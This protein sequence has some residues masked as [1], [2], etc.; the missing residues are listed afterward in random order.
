MYGRYRLQD[1]YTNDATAITETNCTTKI[2]YAT[3]LDH[4]PE[5][6]LALAVGKLADLLRR[7]RDVRAKALPAALKRR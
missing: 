4:V 5:A 2:V 3:D 6:G 7:H 1:R